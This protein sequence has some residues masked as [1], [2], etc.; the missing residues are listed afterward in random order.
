MSRLGSRAAEPALN[1]ELRRRRG[2]SV[3]CSNSGRRRSSSANHAQRTIDL[4]RTDEV[5][6]NGYWDVRCKRC[7][8]EINRLGNDFL[9][10]GGKE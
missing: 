5:G 7:H 6:R 4:L 3:R 8:E 10:L 2:R 1:D 9:L